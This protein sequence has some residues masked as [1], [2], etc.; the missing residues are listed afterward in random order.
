M[1]RSPRL[2]LLIPVALAMTPLAQADYTFAFPTTAADS[3][4]V[5]AEL[6]CQSFDEKKGTTTTLTANAGAIKLTA[7]W[8]AVPAWG[9]QAGIL[10]GMNK[11]WS[12]VDFSGV[13]SVTFSY[14]TGD[15]KTAIEFA[16]NSPKYLGSSTDNGVMMLAPYAGSTSFK[17]VTVGLPDGIAF[18]DWM[19]TQAPDETEVTW[20]DVKTEIKSL[21]F[22][23]KPV[24][25]FAGSAITGAATSTLEIK[26][27]SIQGEVNLGGNWITALGA[28]CSGTQF[29][30]LDNFNGEVAGEP[31]KNRQ[32]GYWFAFTDTTSGIPGLANGKSSLLE[33]ENTFQGIRYIAGDAANVGVAGITAL[34]DKGDAK[35]HPFAGWAGFG[36]GF[37]D[38]TTGE[39]TYLDLT[40]LTGISFFLSMT[41]GFDEANLT[42]VTVKVGNK[43]VG[44]SVAFSAGVPFAKYNNQLICLDI[45]QFKQPGWYTSKVGMK[46]MPLR[47]I[48]RINW[49]IKI[50]SDSAVKA[51]TSS[52]YIGN[53]TFW[54]GYRTCPTV[55]GISNRKVGSKPTLVA[56]YA[57]GLVLS[58]ALEGV[59]SATIE[60]VR[61]DGSRVASFDGAAKMT[62][63]S[64]P[65]NLARGTYL[66]VV[67]HGTSRMVAPFAVMR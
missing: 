25:N 21:Q 41:D 28:T 48:G 58:Y 62:N 4:A 49:E 60:V 26:D 9:A 55:S 61:M 14:K 40:G 39:D 45:C 13:T 50:N 1:S 31:N 29:G 3:A 36:T 18:T 5:N 20:D 44:D 8:G 63:A 27:V 32:G 6:P 15:T 37:K 42:G 16:P 54:K 35:A 24:Y 23:P 17:K 12:P 19:I 38:K 46:P 56:N 65:V 11:R 7:T 10:L 22:S 59:A 52:F 66:A 53:V 30:K 64:F 47:D 33:D 51:A 57:N 67:R 43:S 2:H 34:L